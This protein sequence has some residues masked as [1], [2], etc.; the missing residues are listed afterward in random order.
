MVIIVVLTMKQDLN[1]GRIEA[2]FQELISLDQ[3]RS[4]IPQQ[5]V[6][7][8]ILSS[9]LS[10]TS[11]PEASPVPSSETQPTGARKATDNDELIFTKSDICRE[12]ARL[13]P[14]LRHFGETQT[15][16]QLEDKNSKRIAD[17]EQNSLSELVIY[18]N[19]Q[20][21][22]QLRGPED[23]E[24]HNMRRQSRE[25]EGWVYEVFYRHST[26]EQAQELEQESFKNGYAVLTD[27]LELFA[28]LTF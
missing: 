15:S 3:S 12:V 6:R 14:Y 13:K 11:K 7:G 22:E 28:N 17:E 20:L 8:T 10:A 27:R 5:E 2:R 16:V 18:L 9:F 25:K 4:S 26:S 1:I 24:G 21:C 19:Q 23:E